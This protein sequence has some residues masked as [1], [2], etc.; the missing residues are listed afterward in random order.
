[1]ERLKT[2]SHCGQCL[3]FIDHSGPSEGDLYD[4]LYELHPDRLKRQIEQRKRI[5]DCNQLT[6]E[7]ENNYE[8][9]SDQYARMENEENDRERKSA[10]TLRP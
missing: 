9:S 6:F 1:M 7:G 10:A 3:F 4:G 5:E 2:Y 8:S